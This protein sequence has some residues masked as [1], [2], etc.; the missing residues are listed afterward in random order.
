MVSPPVSSK[1]SNL[2]GLVLTLHLDLQVHLDMVDIG[3]ELDSPI[4]TLHMD[5]PEFSTRSCVR[6]VLLRSLRMS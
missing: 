1:L 5:H 3:K 2:F 6:G 4:W